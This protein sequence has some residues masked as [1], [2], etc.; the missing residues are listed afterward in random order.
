M[1]VIPNDEFD[2]F[3]N[4]VE[5]PTVKFLPRRYVLEGGL[6]VDMRSAIKDDMRRLY[7]LMK[8]VADAGQGYGVDEFPTLNAFRSMTSDVYIIVVEEE[9]SRK[10]RNLPTLTETGPA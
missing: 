5:L 9:S 1:K 7:E 10:V 2:A 3:Y 8:S 4:D 6:A